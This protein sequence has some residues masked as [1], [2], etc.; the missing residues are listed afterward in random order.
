MARQFQEVWAPSTSASTTS[1]R[2]ASRAT[3]RAAG[4]SSRR[5]T[6]TATSTRGATRAGTATAARRSRPKRSSR[7]PA[8]LPHPQDA[9]GPAAGAVL[10][11]RA[12]EVPGPAAGVLRAEPRLHPAGEPAQRDPESRPGRAAGR[13]H[14]APGQTWG[15][16]VPFDADFTIYVWF[17]ALLN[18]ITAIGYGSDEARFEKWWPADIHFIGKDITRFH[19]AL[20]PAMCFAA[21]IAPPRKVFGHGFVYLKKRGEKISKIAGQRRRADGHRRNLP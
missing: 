15:I 6:T 17:D 11:L 16:R 18:Y 3:T 5:C 7:R 4:S 1:S 20:W 12:V 2:P 21:G 9:A 19:C 10:L 14:H 13:Q 8:A